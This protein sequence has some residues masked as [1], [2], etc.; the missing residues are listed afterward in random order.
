MVSNRTK[1]KIGFAVMG[2]CLVALIALLGTYFFMGTRAANLQKDPNGQAATEEAQEEGDAGADGGIDWDY[3]KSVNPDVIGWIEVLGTDIDSPIVQAHAD[4][5]TYYLHHDVYGDRNVY[6]CPYLD[7]GCENQGGLSAPNA[8]VFGHHMNDGSMFADFAKFSDE[9]YLT[10][11]RTI[12]LYTP[13]ATYALNAQAADVVPGWSEI[14][15]TSFADGADFD[16]Y[17]AERLQGCVANVSDG[18]QA[19][20]LTHM[21]TFVTCSYSRWQ[22]ERTLVYAW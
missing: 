12:Y 4:D 15:R 16:G 17:V 13:G 19:A 21:F 20:T 6:G 2:I 18:K 22:N 5:P 7:A 11:H 8:V 1:S 14:K 9:G 3:W 10:A